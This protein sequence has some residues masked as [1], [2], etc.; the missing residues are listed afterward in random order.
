M[1]STAAAPSRTG[2]GTPGEADRSALTIVRRPQYGRW[3]ANAVLALLAI[4][5]IASAVLNPNFQW[6]IVLKYLT[7]RTILSGLWVTIEL[8]VIAMSLAIALGVLLA[9]L[10]LSGDAWLKTFAAAYIWLFR[11]TPLLVQLIFWFNISALYPEISIGIP[12]GPTLFS[13]SGNSITPFMA[14]AIGLTLHE[15]AYMSEIVR[16]GVLSVGH[17]Q[18]EAGL[19]I[20]MT[21]LKAFRR[22]TLP[23]A[24]RAIVPATGNQVIL[25]LKTTSLVSVIA[26]PELLYS[27][28][29][30][31]A[32][33]FEII[34]LL[35]VASLWYLFM[36]TLLSI[37]QHFLE[38]RFGRGFQQPGG[39]I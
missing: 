14:A 31:Y 33:T 28:Q 10:T 21:R 22:I 36:C 37:G 29:I 35:V 13:F 7:N 5:I 23:Q 20:G 39:T 16:G 1:K 9:L 6:D 8:T 26:L 18:G 30:I 24:L 17:G 2:P 25:M 11:G 12:G 15:A 27:A 3:A 38:R 34:P 19:A 32:R 4:G